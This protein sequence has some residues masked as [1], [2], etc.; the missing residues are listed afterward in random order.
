MM[1]NMTSN[2]GFFLP[3]AMVAL[4]AIFLFLMLVPILFASLFPIVKYVLMAFF[5]IAIFTFVSRILGS[6]WLA[7]AVSGVLI[8]IF[9]INLWQLLTAASVLFYLIAFGL[10]GIIMFSLPHG[11]GGGGAAKKAMG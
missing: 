9:V 4:I 5:A 7:Y 3:V 8:F 6:G 11:G 1:G 10:S 2:K